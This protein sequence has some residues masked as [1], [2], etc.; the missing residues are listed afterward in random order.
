MKQEFITVGGIRYCYVDQQPNQ[1]PKATLL[2]LHGFPDQW[3]GWENQIAAWS[4]A[5]YRV[6]VPHMLGYGLSDKPSAAASYS[7]KNLSRD[8]AFLLDGLQLDSVIV[9]AHDWGAAVAWRFALWY[10][11]RV[12]ALVTLSVPY[13]PPSETY[14]P[15]SEASKR[16]PTFAYQEYFSDPSSTRE[17]ETNLDIFIPALFQTPRPA[18]GGFADGKL[19]V[20]RA[21]QMQTL[22]KNGKESFN[23]PPTVIPKHELERYILDFQQGGMNGPLSYYRNT[24]SRFDDEKEAGLPTAFPSSIPVLFFYG[25]KDGTC[26]QS[27][28][29]RMP[30]FVPNLTIVPLEGK[31]HWLLLEATEQ[32][33][34]TVLE[35]LDKVRSGSGGLVGEAIASVRL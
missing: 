25:T 10:P 7:T 32:I 8:L 24:R 30:M 22:L 4:Q 3:Y 26:P 27:F 5:G 19:P 20:L 35:F 14:I 6:I 9:I 2:G 13:F 21:G 15:I 1:Q 17:I 29:S 18:N 34:S 23:I 11:N 28:V 12:R 33:N 31:G 16:V